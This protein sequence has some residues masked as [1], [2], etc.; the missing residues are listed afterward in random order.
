MLR[1]PEGLLVP[2]MNFIRRWLL[3]RR[4]VMEAVSTWR[5]ERDFVPPGWKPY[6][7]RNGLRPDLHADEKEWRRGLRR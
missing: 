7:I 6:S 4:L 2:Y 5:T 1:L 3:R